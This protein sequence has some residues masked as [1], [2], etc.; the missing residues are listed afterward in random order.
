M[1]AQKY[2]TGI[3]SHSRQYHSHLTYAV[4]RAVV[5]VAG[6]CAHCVVGNPTRRPSIHVW[7]RDSKGGVL[8]ATPTAG[9]TQGPCPPVT[10]TRHWAGLLIA[11]P[12]AHN[13]VGGFT[14]LAAKSCC[15]G[16]TENCSAV[17]RAAG[18]TAVSPVAPF[19]PTV[20]RTRLG[21]ACLA[22]A[23]AVGCLTGGPAKVCRSCDG[24]DGRLVA[25]CTCSCAGRPI[26]P[27]CDAVYGAGCRVGAACCCPAGITT[28]RPGVCVSCMTGPGRRRH[29]PLLAC[30]AKCLPQ[31]PSIAEVVRAFSQL[32]R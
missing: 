8:T 31:V 13:V 5:G 6:L 12:I 28:P 30:T 4:H 32:S 7:G 14:L 22:A 24:V 19:T 25:S 16:H 9:I 29:S 27:T 1:P 15:F 21:V 3:G 11:C 10:H 26:A 17:P 20:L 18:S 2:S 23:G